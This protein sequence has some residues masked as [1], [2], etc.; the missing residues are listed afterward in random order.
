VK[1]DELIRAME[2]DTER[3]RPVGAVLPVALLV[4]AAVLAAVFLP[5]MGPR[6]DLGPGMI[7]LPVLVKQAFPV[8]VTLGAFGAALR[9]ARPG[10]GVGGW[11]LLLAAV[12]VLLGLEVAATMAAMPEAG[13]MPAMMGQSNGQC[14]GFITLMS[15]PLLA[16]ALWVLRSGASTRP[17]LS[18]AVAGLLSG[19]AAAVV[20][21]VH[22]TEDSPLFYAVWYVLAILIATGAGALLGARFLRW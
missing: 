18:G 6:P 16:V 1:T 3:P 19:G 13:W 7:T 14:V 5:A 20:Y 22:C 11:A 10:M 17:V 9:L 2:A 21:S 8:L 12:P 4:A 15:L